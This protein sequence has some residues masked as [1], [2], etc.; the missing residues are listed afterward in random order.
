MFIVVFLVLFAIE[1]FLLY[2]CCE[3]GQLEAGLI[4]ILALCISR[5]LN[6]CC[7]MYGE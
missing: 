4:N 1:L 2:F 5:L 6:V 3:H 7:R